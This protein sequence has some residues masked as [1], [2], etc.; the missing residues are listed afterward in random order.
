MSCIG[1]WVFAVL[2]LCSMYLAYTAVSPACNFILELYND[3]YLSSLQ[4]MCVTHGFQQNII[5]VERTI[6][7]IFCAAEPTWPLHRL[8]KVEV[9]LHAVKLELQIMKLD[10]FT[11]AWSPQLFVIDLYTTVT[12]HYLF[13]AELDLFFAEFDFGTWSPRW[14]AWIFHCEAWVFHSGV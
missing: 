5:E 1:W 12:E 4:Q 11:W 7:T 2:F 8:H 10:L 3:N 9:D 14:W 6:F 13:T